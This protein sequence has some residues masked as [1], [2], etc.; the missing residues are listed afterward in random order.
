MEQ[1]EVQRLVVDPED[2]IDP[3]DPGAAAP[4]LETTQKRKKVEMYNTLKSGS[5]S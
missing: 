1:D 3:E 4:G 2:P 5:I